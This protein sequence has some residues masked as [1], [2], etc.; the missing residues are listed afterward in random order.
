MK[1][2]R[3]VLVR[4]IIKH[5]HAFFKLLDHIDKQDGSSE[6]PEHL[7]I[8]VYN[9][10]ICLD[11][12]DPSQDHLTVSSLIDNGVFIHN[13]KNTG[14]ITLE[15]VI[16][17]LLRFLDV[18]RAKELTKTD[19]ENLRAQMM[20]IVGQ[21]MSSK[22]GTQDYRD[23]MTAFNQL[24]SETHSKIKENV[25]GLISQVESLASEYKAYDSD[26][27][28][29]SV[30]D[31]YEK[32]SVLNN[33]FVMPCYEFIDPVMEM[34]Q[35]DTFS[36]AIEILIEY[37]SS[38]EMRQFDTANAIQFRK[39]AITSYYKDIAVLVQKLERFS[40]HLEKDRK[41]FLAFEASFNDLMDS[42]IPL[43]HGKKKNKYLKNSD[44]VFQEG[45][46]FDGLITQKSRFS[47]TLNWDEEITKLR[48]KEYLIVIKDKQIQSRPKKAGL[49]PLPS[50]QNISQHRQILISKILYGEVLPNEIA[51]VHRYIFELLGKKLADFQ[52]F[53]V[54]YGLEAFLPAFGAGQ[55]QDLVKNRINDDN[56]YFEYVQLECK[57]EIDLV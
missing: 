42:I 50:N 56:Y 9:N 14:M 28:E 36:K 18:N 26:S 12:D 30:V 5:Q 33:R 29:I 55:R 13:D 54:L 17:D 32:V 40:S 49:L 19:F 3:D 1:L 2:N 15:R 21:V 51:D 23:A 22:V 37:H 25:L 48:F 8:T 7:Y 41:Y 44:N 10:I 16:V 39:T 52:L 57:K 4:A 53:D 47:A 24:M 11:P 35:T 20:R 6:V 27:T 46:V 38:D 45:C 31:L 43:R 34:S